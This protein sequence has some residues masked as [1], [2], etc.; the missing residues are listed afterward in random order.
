MQ[1]TQRGPGHGAVSESD[2][3][4]EDEEV[5][6]DEMDLDGQADSQDQVVKKL[7]RYAL[8]CEFQRIPIKRVGISEKGQHPTIPSF[9]RANCSSSG[10]AAWQ[11]QGGIRCSSKAFAIQIRHGDDRTTGK[12]ESHH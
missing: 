1:V 7:V 3:D 12:R 6:Y 10:E 8:A 4:A 9:L 2:S 11:L 5:G